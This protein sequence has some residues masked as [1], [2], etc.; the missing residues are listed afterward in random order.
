MRVLFVSPYTLRGC[1]EAEFG[2]LWARELRKVGVFVIEYDGSWPAVYGR[3][4]VYLPPPEELRHIDLIHLNWGPAN[5]GHYLPSHLPQG[6]PLSLF[7]AD[8]PPNSS[9]ALHQFADVVFAVEPAD[10][11]TVISHHVPPY[12][13]PFFSLPDLV[14]IGTTGIRGDAGG[15][16]L[17]DLCARRGW[18]L[19]ESGPWRDTDQEIERL[20]GCTLNVLWYH[21]TGRGTSQAASYC[22]AAR[23][24]LVL[25]SSS[26]FDYLLPWRDEVYR[27]PGEPLYTADEYSGR[28]LEAMIEVVLED[29]R[30]RRDRQPSR[31]LQE[32][33]WERLALQIKAAWAGVVRR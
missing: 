7:L 15:Q 16:V 9:T 4:H 26:M 14:T 24:P 13:G 22:L 3:G 23:R 11:A 30:E 5:M 25:S 19:S 27:W 28:R 6:M 8:V 20:A 21:S 18:A 2:R 12:Q 33:A 31:V 29:I 32:L 10:R 1:G 17:R